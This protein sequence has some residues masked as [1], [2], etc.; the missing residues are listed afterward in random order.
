MTRWVSSLLRHVLAGEGGWCCK[1]ALGKSVGWASR[2]VVE[3]AQGGFSL[4]AV[5]F[6]GEEIGKDD[7]A[8]VLRDVLAETNDFRVWVGGG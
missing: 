4:G 1:E 5:R 2:V 8:V 3:R 7:G 6:E